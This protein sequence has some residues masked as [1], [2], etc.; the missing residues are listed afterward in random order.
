MQVK[1][2]HLKVFQLLAEIAIPL[3][4]YFFWNWGF[5]FILLFFLLDYL[6]FLT[7]SFVKHRKIV[8]FRET[9]YFFPIK[10]VLATSLVLIFTFIF[11][12]IA[13]PQLG[14]FD[15]VAQ[16]WEFISYKEMGIPQGILLLP[17]VVYGGYA[18]YKMQFL[19]NGKFSK[20]SAT[21][22]W[23]SHFFFL[24]MA[25][26]ASLLFYIVSYFFFIPEIIYIGGLLFGIAVFKWFF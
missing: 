17:L 21:E 22:N 11:T 8:Q 25:F 10:Q 20:T 3:L 24:W 2:I 12:F 1:P 23:K 5:Y 9:P 13:L 19:M 7:F 16:T 26:F 15:F 4:G 14:A 6:V 18:Q